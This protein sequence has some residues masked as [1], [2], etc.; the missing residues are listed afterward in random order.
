MP[1]PKLA[2]GGAEFAGCAVS[3]TMGPYPCGIA[4]ESTRHWFAIAQPAVVTAQRTSIFALRP[5]IN[6]HGLARVF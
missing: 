2:G 6:H 4:A 1:L 5:R 3:L